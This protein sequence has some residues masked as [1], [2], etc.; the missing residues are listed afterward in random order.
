MWTMLHAH[1][2]HTR[3]HMH[4]H[5]RTQHHSTINARTDARASTAVFT[6][7]REGAAGGQAVVAAFARLTEMRDAGQFDRG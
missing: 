6:S 7:D 2:Q 5:A 1:A 3:T 4:T